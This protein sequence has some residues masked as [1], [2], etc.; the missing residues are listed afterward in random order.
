MKTYPVY[1]G[2]VFRNSP[3]TLDVHCP[4]T[5]QV[6]AKVS[7][8]NQDI[9]EKSITSA[10]NVQEEMAS[11]PSYEKYEALRYIS[12]TIHSN[13]TELATI[14]CLESAKPMRYSLGEV[15][16]AAQTFLVAAEESKRLPEEYMRLDWTAA[17]HDREAIVKSYPI[18]IIAGISPFNFP[19]NLPAHKIAPAIATGC[20]IILKPSSKTPLST[21]E[22]AKIIDQTNL[23]KGA[24]SI[25]PMHKEIG[26]LMV[27]EE[28]FSMLSF[29]GS[30][31]VGWKMK[32]EAGNKKVVLELGGN[33]GVLVNEDA[34]LKNIITSCIMGAFAYSGQVCIHAQRIFIHENV[35]DH[36]V[37]LFVAATENL[38]IGDP[39]SLDTDVSSMIDE[40]NAI[41]VEKWVNEAIDAGA[42]LLTGGIRNGSLY[43]PTVLTNT[44][45]KM[46]VCAEEVFGP[47][48]ILESVAGF[49]DGIRK[50]NDSKFG[51]QA[52]IFTNNV[53]LL[54][55]AF[56]ALKVGGVIHNDV[57]TF[58]ADHMPYGGVKES[59]LG[60]EGVKYAMRDMLE[61]K[62]LVL[63]R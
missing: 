62:V 18:G 29:T 31:A 4:Y 13:R 63:K 46:K 2:G 7:I 49:E 16:R 32:T 40:G 17:A 35:F 28:R 25:L 33:A 60:R 24:V 34:D 54:W 3:E 37:T 43:K 42:E 51:L 38:K 59:G 21:F 1:A 55:K 36:F 22:L 39:S 8:A 58:R 27:A 44:N 52:G 14:L 19:L 41:R 11:L 56:D 15:D 30:P 10:L 12:D 45:N 53:Q 57:P 5:G 20:P 61:P 23:P 9:L 6:F 26:N 50:L 48:V 47:V